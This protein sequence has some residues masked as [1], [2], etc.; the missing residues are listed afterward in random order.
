MSILGKS[1]QSWEVNGHIFGEYV[2][3]CGARYIEL[4]SREESY[5]SIIIRNRITLYVL[6]VCDNQE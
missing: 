3:V 6:C 5:A 1:C 4:T 2:T